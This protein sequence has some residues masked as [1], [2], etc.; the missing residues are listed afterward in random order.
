[1][2][3]YVGYSGTR[4][5]I[6]VGYRGCAITLLENRAFEWDMNDDNNDGCGDD[7]AVDLVSRVLFCYCVS[8]DVIAK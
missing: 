4:V 2:M 3:I 6:F 1:M 7:G 8:G 5:L